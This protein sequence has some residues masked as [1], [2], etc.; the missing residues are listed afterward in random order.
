MKIS[1]RT[2]MTIA[3]YNSTE[4]RPT[5]SMVKYKGTHPSAKKILSTPASR[6]INEGRAP[7][8]CRMMVPTLC[9]LILSNGG[10]AYC[11]MLEAKTP[12]TPE[13]WAARN[14]CTVCG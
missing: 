8:D 4:R 12:S 10:M 5:R 11:N 3:P 6:E 7:V 1:M 13:S 14:K 2:D 9:Q